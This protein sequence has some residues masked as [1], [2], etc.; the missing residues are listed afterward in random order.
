MQEPAC[1]FDQLRV[2]SEVEG[3]A[4]LPSATLLRQAEL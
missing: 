2:P 3:Q 4:I 1:P